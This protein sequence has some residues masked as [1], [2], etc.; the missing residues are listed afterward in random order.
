MIRCARQQ[1]RSTDRQHHKCSLFLIAFIWTGMSQ[2]PPSKLMKYD[3]EE[4]AVEPVEPVQAAPTPLENFDIIQRVVSFVGPNKY[5]FVASINNDFKS[6]Y[7]TLFP[8]N[9]STY[10]NVYTKE[11]AILHL[12]CTR[13]TTNPTIVAKLCTSTARH[14]N[15]LALQYLKS[16]NV[17]WDCSTSSTAAKFGHLHIVQYLFSNG[18]PWDK[19]TCSSAA[20]NGHLEALQWAHI[21]HCPWDADTCSCAALNGHLGVLQWA[22]ANGCPWNGNTY[23]SAALNG[24]IEILRWAHVNYCPWAADTCSCCLCC[25]EW[26]FRNSAVGT[27]TWLSMGCLHMQSCS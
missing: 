14:G 17:R 15:L 16:M 21:N 25:Q 20:L 3:A 8:N 10:Y 24:H 23:S 2:E 13:A 11:D 9:R 12:K 27:Y 1:K 22:H 4:E 19:E 7:S 5:Y 6:A 18:C 26:S